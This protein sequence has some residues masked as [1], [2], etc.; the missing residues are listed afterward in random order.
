MTLT[1]AGNGRL[2]ATPADVAAHLARAN[3]FDSASLEWIG[4]RIEAMKGE[5]GNLLAPQQLHWICGI[6]DADLR[7][8]AAKILAARA[9]EGPTLR[10][11]VSD[12]A[13]HDAAD[14]KT[15]AVLVI[16]YMKSPAPT[17]IAL[18]KEALQSDELA[19]W[20]EASRALGRLARNVREAER[21][22]LDDGI[23]V[24]RT[25]PGCVLLCDFNA[26]AGRRLVEACSATDETIRSTAA[27][28]LAD[29][30]ASLQKYPWETMVPMLGRLATDGCVDVQ[31]AALD[32]LQRALP[33]SATAARHLLSRAS[34]AAHPL[35]LRAVRALA[36]GCAG[37]S[38][39]AQAAERLVAE[40]DAS[41]LVALALGL[42]IPLRD[43]GMACLPLM[44]QIARSDDME[45]Q[46][47]LADVLC[48]AAALRPQLCMPI[49]ERLVHDRCGMRPFECFRN[50]EGPLSR[51]CELFLRMW[52]VEEDPTAQLSALV[53]AI[54]ESG[55]D[56][57]I[58][59]VYRL[60]EKLTQ[61]ATMDEILAAA[62]DLG[63]VL[64]HCPP[65]L[66]HLSEPLTR[67]H[68][69]I[70][71]LSS[72]ETQ[73]DPETQ[74]KIIR[75]ALK[76]LEALRDDFEQDKLLP[77]GHFLSALAARW[78]A[79]V[80]QTLFAAR[81]G[82]DLVIEVTERRVRRA[83]SSNMTV[84]VK[85]AGPGIAYGV[86]VE[87][88][89][90]ENYS[91]QQG[92]HQIHNI[93]PE[94]SCM[95]DFVFTP[96][97]ADSFRVEFAA[98]YSD[99]AEA[100]RTTRYAEDVVSSSDQG[101]SFVAIPNPY[102]P[103]LP[104]DL[105]SELFLGREDVFKFL[106]ENFLTAPKRVILLV[107]QRRMGKTSI[108][109]QLP[110]RL[111]QGFFPVFVD[112]QG[113]EHAGIGNLLYH[114]AY[115]VSDTLA[116]NNI[117]LPIPDLA[118][119]QE[120]PMF[121]FEYGFLKPALAKLSGRTMLI[122]LDEFQALDEAVE[123]GQLET[124]IFG[125]LRSMMQHQDKLC[126]LFSGLQRPLE[127]AHDLWQPVFNVALRK[128]VGLLEVNYARELIEKP[129]AGRMQYDESALE[130]LLRL[131]CGH[132]YLTQLFCDRIIS[133][134]N[135]IKEHVARM[136]HIHEVIPHVFSAGV[137]HF[138]SLWEDLSARE[139]IVLIAMCANLS[140]H[141][142]V[143]LSAITR[144]V[145]E[146]GIAAELDDVTTVLQRLLGHD[147][148]RYVHSQPP[149]YAF[150]VHLFRLWIEKE[151][152]QALVGGKLKWN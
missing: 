53:A 32:G 91:I 50:G 24:H 95:L 108:L 20:W 105:G 137:N 76:D 5:T 88:L 59:S 23:A 19:V 33:Y 133:H 132:P 22:L 102:I 61:F 67:L 26:A 29:P 58:V 45:V 87:M 138:Y 49:L 64:Q 93:G 51:L 2:Q 71:S 151:T 56:S 123:S 143:T 145:R 86:T 148:I 97:D 72:F 65:W 109:K 73:T 117:D 44:V 130:E 110:L 125:F 94:E 106:Q 114:L 6:E 74:S 36:E 152:L 128:E 77:L 31:A 38:E 18:L 47:T 28:C 103:G 82:A 54:D 135:E 90:S 42:A 30:D 136:Q 41:T 121:S 1:S 89:A 113:L 142:F 52:K 84:R 141:Q 9:D 107:G 15:M 126:F 7:Q 140:R 101:L 34:D 150:K 62:A 40:G 104:L 115:M 111:P 134:L 75:Q 13:S 83:T 70:D 43:D 119:F 100:E 131:T 55:T 149:G 12:L 118:T 127:E 120:R 85:N 21:I 69:W 99:F 39:A 147:M 144:F 4:R 8:E 80:L 98:R 124:E 66:D 78:K 116:A 10:S 46:I 35:R 68:R 37:S 14:E 60:L 146:R 3:L 48:D 63:G 122:L 17:E 96:T 25:L 81:R 92:S 11:W 79:V 129:V 139:K 16:G 27:R 57:K 112:C